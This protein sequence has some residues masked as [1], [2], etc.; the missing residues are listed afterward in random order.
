[1]QAGAENNVAETDGDVTANRSAATLADGFIESFE[2]RYPRSVLETLL[3][4]RT[5]GRNIIW[6]DGEY[7]QLG[8]DLSQRDAFMHLVG[9]SEEPKK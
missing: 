6:A 7:E 2:R 8:A 9:H 4:D 3:A 5:T 1:M